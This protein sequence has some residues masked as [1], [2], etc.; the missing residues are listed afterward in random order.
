MQGLLNPARWL[1][2]VERAARE[3]GE[4]ELTIAAE[5][6]RIVLRARMVCS[7]CPLGGGEPCAMGCFLHEEEDG[8]EGLAGGGG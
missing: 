3:A 1:E 8:F 5:L 2:L 6:M 4:K 7:S